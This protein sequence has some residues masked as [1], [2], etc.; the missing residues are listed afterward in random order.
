MKWLGLFV[1]LLLPTAL[2]AASLPPW[3]ENA[4]AQKIPDAFSLSPAVVLLHEVTIAPAGSDAVKESHR[5]VAQLMRAEGASAVLRGIHMSA[6]DQ[7][8]SAEAWHRDAEGEVEKIRRSQAVKYTGSDDQVHDAQSVILPLTKGQGGDLWAME[9]TVIRRPGFGGGGWACPMNLPVMSL[10]LCL[11]EPGPA[12]G[13]RGGIAAPA[14]GGGCYR[15]PPMDKIEEEPWDPP[16]ADILPR[17]DWVLRK[18]TWASAG[19]RYLGLA[20]LPAALTL[21][22]VTGAAAPQSWKTSAEWVRKQVRYVAVELGRGAFIPTPPAETLQKQWG[23]CKD[24]SYLLIAALKA[25]GRTAHPILVRTRP[26]GGLQEALPS[27]HYFDHAIVAVE[28]TAEEAAASKAVAAVDGRSYIIVDPTDDTSPLGI[29]HEDIQGAPGLLLKDE[30]R[31]ITLPS[32]APE[33]NRVVCRVTIDPGVALCTVKVEESSWGGRFAAEKRFASNKS[34]EEIRTKLG[35]Y[36]A[37]FLSKP[38]LL[39]FTVDAQRSEEPFTLSYAFQDGGLMKRSGNL[40]MLQPVLP[41][42]LSGNIFPDKPRQTPFDIPVSSAAQNEILVKVPEFLELL[43]LPKSRSVTTALFTYTL[44][45]GREGDDVVVHR[46]FR[47]LAGQLPAEEAELLRKAFVETVKGDTS[48]LLF[49]ERKATG[50]TQ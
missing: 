32:L 15:W 8:E 48:A 9:Y 43:E 27:L 44:N 5:Y 26:A 18:E 4:A 31:L 36:L 21:P 25:A 13:V 39:D 12:H 22:G 42:R 47:K 28:A 41:G 3:A 35:T 50:E 33:D 24:K 46:E 7:L 49:R 6:G 23:D 16:N 1:V 17:V 2:M 37:K 14:S 30:P 29:L 40:L 11:P 34:P 45:F 38:R 20:P 10:V 19:R